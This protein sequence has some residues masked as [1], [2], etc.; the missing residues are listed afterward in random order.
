MTTNDKQAVKILRDA[1]MQTEA[2][3]VLFN[4]RMYLQDRARYE[5]LFI[6]SRAEREARAGY[7]D[8]RQ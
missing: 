1:Y 6:A 7:I 8:G 3:D 2:S 5:K 4:A